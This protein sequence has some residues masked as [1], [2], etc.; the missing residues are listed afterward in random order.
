MFGAHAD[1]EK[2]LFAEVFAGVFVE[3]DQVVVVVN[4]EHLRGIAHTEGVALALIH[5]N[6]N[7]HSPI[8]PC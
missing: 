1:G 4:L 2:D 6:F 7:T 8:L 5:I 3:D